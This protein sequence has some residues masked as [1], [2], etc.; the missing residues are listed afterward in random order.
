MHKCHKS[1]D[2]ISKHIKKIKDIIP[3][4]MMNAITKKNIPYTNRNFAE[5]FIR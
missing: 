1:G 3:P 5:S 2:K 4:N